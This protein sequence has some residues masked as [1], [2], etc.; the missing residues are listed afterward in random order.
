MYEV[1]SESTSTKR[2]RDVSKSWIRVKGRTL[3][4][5]K[6]FANLVRRIESLDVT[7]ARYD[8]K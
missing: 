7:D 1:R 3:A 5:R 6:S 8:R 4:L 2:S